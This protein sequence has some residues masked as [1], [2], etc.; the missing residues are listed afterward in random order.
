MAGDVSENGIL[1]PSPM[2]LGSNSYEQKKGSFNTVQSDCISYTCSPRDDVDL[3]PGGGRRGSILKRHR[4]SVV[5]EKTYRQY[6]VLEKTPETIK[7]LSEALQTDVY[8]PD[9]MNKWYWDT[10]LLIS[11]AYYSIFIPVQYTI[12]R[13]DLVCSEVGHIIIESISSIIYIIDIYFGFNTAVLNEL[14]GEL[15]DEPCKIRSLYLNSDFIWDFLAACPLD[16]FT[17]VFLGEG[18]ADGW[19]WFSLSHLRLFKLRA[20][21]K[22]FKVVTPVKLGP[23]SVSY[24]YTV[25]PII[26]LI[27]YCALA[28]NLITV[29]WILINKEGPRGISTSEYPYIKAL[30]WTLYTVTSVGYGDIPVDTQQKQMFASVLFVAGVVIHG[31][32][33]SKIS[34]R[35]QKGD[36]ESDRTDKM[37]ETLSVLKKFSIPE[38][39]ACE[40]LAFQYHQLHSDVSG[41]FMKVLHTLPAVMRDRVGLF[42][43][44]RFICQV[45][46]FKEQPIE[47]LVGLANALKSL[48]LEPES[49]IIKAGDEGREMFF[50]GHGFADVTAPDGHLWGIIKPGGF[51]GEIALLTDS[52]RTASI[53]TLTYCDL[54]RLDK[55]EFFKLIRKHPELRNAVREE[56]IH[57]QVQQNRESCVYHLEQSSP[58]DV[59]GVVWGTYSDRFIVTDIAESGAA[60]RVGIVQGMHLV[61]IEDDLIDSN[62][63]IDYLETVFQE[64]GHIRLTLLPPDLM[65]GYED[66]SLRE[67]MAIESPP[68]SPRS[69]QSPLQGCHSYDEVS[70]SSDIS[71]SPRRRQTQPVGPR[72][73]FGVKLPDIKVNDL[74]QKMSF[75]QM[76][77]TRSPSSADVSC[78][79]S[80]LELKTETMSQSV[81]RI[82]AYVRSLV[83]SLDLSVERNENPEKNHS[84]VENKNRRTSLPNRLGN[85]F[86]FNNFHEGSHMLVCHDSYHLPHSLDDNIILNSNQTECLN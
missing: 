21:T 20:T 44:M 4:S 61:A 49:R 12:K 7:R 76:T 73:S 26:R 55:N 57:R 39:L 50:M 41:S 70:Q 17:M 71:P 46:M 60:Y 5:S 43:R 45:P 38:Q 10:I 69:L 72:G 22:L 68:L 33:I 14:T 58:G 1:T 16:T 63:Q 53:T 82:E 31:I 8:Q 19:V 74:N 9:D 36:V 28:I 24:Q 25:V 78:R 51:F 6:A 30:Y 84:D 77:S 3:S 54:F 59:V 18:Y 47:C 66:D 40:V 86:N 85:A 11:I 48:V 2:R 29:C 79:L 64:I 81:V 75:K 13:T 83:N 37:K 27:F 67:P 35:M 32:V 65:I 52:Q 80:R 15:V 23:H 56:M 34:S 62:D 42:V